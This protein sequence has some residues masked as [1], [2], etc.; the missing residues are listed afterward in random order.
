MV[1]L[2]GKNS[3]NKLDNLSP[4]LI[5]PGEQISRYDFNALE[6]AGDNIRRADLPKL[7]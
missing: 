4:V 2:T 7:M 3:Y 1:F 6:F 5:K